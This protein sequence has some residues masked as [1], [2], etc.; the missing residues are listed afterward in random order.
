MKKKIEITYARAFFCI[1]IVAIHSFPGLLNDADTPDASLP[2]YEFLRVLLLFA[3]PSFII[4]SEILLSMRYSNGLPD[5]FFLKRIKFILIPYILIGTFFSLMNYL[6]SDGSQGFFEI[7]TNNVLYG[8]WHGW[9]II[10]IFQFYILHALFYKWLNKA[11]P[12]IMLVISFLISLTHSLLAYA[13]EPYFQWWDTYY[14][15]HN[16][17]ALPFWIF[18]FIFGYYLG[19]NYERIMSSV[20]RHL[21]PLCGLWAL[22]VLWIFIMYHFFDVTYVKSYRFDLLLYTVFTFLLVLYLM[23]VIGKHKF[24]LLLLISDVSFFIYLSHPLVNSY[25][26]KAL[27]SFVGVPSIFLILLTL[28]TLGF[29]LGMAFVLSHFPLSRFVIGK[30]SLHKMLDKHFSHDAG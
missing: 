19:K 14:P 8:N 11:N 2:F 30:N 15:F 16:R 24:T 13:Y 6:D 10:V 23:Q 22:S 25:L 21:W 12:L 27:A 18:Y 20:K 7:F 4:L 17:T 3:T 1:T 28:F 26:S 9:F 5:D 29:S